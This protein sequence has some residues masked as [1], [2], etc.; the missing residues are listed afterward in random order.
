LDE[1]LV[2]AYVYMLCLGCD[3]LNKAMIIPFEFVYNC[4]HEVCRRFGDLFAIEVVYC[5]SPK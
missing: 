1:G 4:K 2:N 5:K 3:D